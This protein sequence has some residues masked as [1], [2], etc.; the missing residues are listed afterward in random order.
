VT[1]TSALSLHHSP[2][3]VM[4]KSDQ[5]WARD[6]SSCKNHKQHLLQSKTAQDFQGAIGDVS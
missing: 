1:Q 5:L 2:A 6:D 3:G 4:C